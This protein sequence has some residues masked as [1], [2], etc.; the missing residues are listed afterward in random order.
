VWPLR[1]GS[2]LIV[3]RSPSRARSVNAF[4]ASKISR[5]FGLTDC[6]ADPY[7]DSIRSAISPFPAARST[8]DAGRPV[9]FANRRQFRT[10]S[11]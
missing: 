11:L 3:N 4:H 7:C 2:S 6:A 8:T 9:A 5:S 10:F 1:C